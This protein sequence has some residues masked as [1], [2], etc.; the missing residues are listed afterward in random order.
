[1]ES[2]DS[3]IPRSIGL[4]CTEASASVHWDMHTMHNTCDC[5][6]CNSDRTPKKSGGSAKSH[7]KDHN[8]SGANIIRKIEIITTKMKVT[9][10][11]I[12]EVLGRI[13]Q[14]DYVL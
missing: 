6:R 8:P 5:N 13:A 10:T 2:T 11:L 7:Q 1:M 4:K 3:R 14:R 12:P 9:L